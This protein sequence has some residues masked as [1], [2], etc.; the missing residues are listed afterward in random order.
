M[1]TLWISLQM[2]FLI[3]INRWD[4]FGFI[5][6]GPILC[7]LHARIWDNLLTYKEFNKNRVEIKL[8]K[9]LRGEMWLRRLQALCQ[10]Y[11]VSHTLGKFSSILKRFLFKEWISTKLQQDDWW[12]FLILYKYHWT[13][14]LVVK[15]SRTVCINKRYYHTYTVFL[16]VI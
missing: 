12:R 10:N 3:C 6:L 16:G 1:R 2:T 13:L 11:I 5:S 9:P 4:K 14:Q 7:H 15:K 8:Q